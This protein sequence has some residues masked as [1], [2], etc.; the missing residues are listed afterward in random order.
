MARTTPRIG[1]TE[2]VFAIASPARLRQ[3]LGM[4]DIP[5]RDAAT[6]I[7]LRDIGD[8]PH[9]LM[10]QRG[11]SAAFMPSKFVFPGGAVDD[12]DGALDLTGDLDP[13][14]LA[15][16]RK[17]ADFSRAPAL[18]TAAIREAWEETGL[19]FARP[20]ASGDPAPKIAFPDWNGF[21]ATGTRPSATGFTFVFRAITPPGRPRRFDARFFMVSADHILGDPDDFSAASDELSHLQWVAMPEIRKLDLPFITEVVL[22]E[23]RGLLANGNRPESVPF[24]YHGVTASEFLRL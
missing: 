19:R 5:V 13:E 18:V 2:T 4:N 3:S 16:L 1:K 14:C 8:V 7:I 11:K 20:H 17:E 10:G 6:V 12:A 15:R 9:I 22:A 23:V 24:F 21:S